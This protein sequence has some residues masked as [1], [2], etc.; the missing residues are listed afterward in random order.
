VQTKAKLEAE[1]AALAAEVHEVTRRHGR[2]LPTGSD[3]ADLF[4]VMGVTWD[5]LH[6]AVESG[7]GDVAVFS[8]LV[9][10]GEVTPAAEPV[11]EALLAAVL[12]ALAGDRSAYYE[13]LRQLRVPL[14]ELLV[15]RATR[16]AHDWVASS[17]FLYTYREARAWVTRTPLRDP[18]LA[19]APSAPEE[20]IRTA[21]ARAKGW[22]VAVCAGL[23]LRL[24]AT[25]FTEWREWITEGAAK[26]QAFYLREHA[27]A[28]PS[29][30]EDPADLWQREVAR[31]TLPE[32]EEA[33][34]V[35]RGVVRGEALAAV[36]ALAPIPARHTDQAE[37]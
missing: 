23:G 17:E 6:A 31:H 20:A 32:D 7:E 18:P 29:C 9:L 12:A 1:I 14:G 21:S 30:S 11:R 34:L 27:S 8:G 33:E 5:E 19:A 22:Q 37:E 3:W 24:S 36:K 35:R 28:N 26:W 15:R 10:R 4:E 25:E 13:A 16:W 2:S